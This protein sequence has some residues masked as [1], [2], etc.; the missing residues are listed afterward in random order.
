MAIIVI[1]F[2]RT[3]AEQRQLEALEHFS[4]RDKMEPARA[5]AATDIW[6]FDDEAD[7]IY[8]ADGQH[9]C[10]EAARVP[11]LAESLEIRVGCDIVALTRPFIERD[12]RA[13]DDKE[14]KGLIDEQSVEV[15][16]SFHFRIDCGGPFL[17][18]QVQQVA[19]LRTLEL[20]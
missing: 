8:R 5:Q 13:G 12:N 10:R 19:V 17:V 14:V 2:R 3:L 4:L 20:T 18:G 9:G 15:H 7:I 6:I 1:P 16:G 11:V